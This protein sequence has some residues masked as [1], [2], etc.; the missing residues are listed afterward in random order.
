MALQLGALRAALLDAG[1]KPDAA[2][3]ASEEVALYENRLAGVEGRMS[4]LTWMVG[5]N[6]TLTLVVIGSLFLLWS[7]IGEMS[8]QLAQ[9]AARVH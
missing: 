5:A 9:I 3:R 8:G 6:V 1:A 4:V 2:D 7:K